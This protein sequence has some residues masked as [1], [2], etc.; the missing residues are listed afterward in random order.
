MRHFSILERAW[1][2]TWR[3]RALWIFGLLVALTAGGTSSGGGSGGNAAGQA[4]DQGVYGGLELP[5]PVIGFFVAL[6]VVLVIALILAALIFALFASIARYLGDSA[7]MQL[8]DREEADGT[9]PTLAAG[10]RLSWSTATLRLFALDV[11]VGIPTAIIS[12]VLILFS[13]TPLLLWFTEDVG[14]GIVGTVLAVGLFIFVLLFISLVSALISIFTPFYRRRTV[15]AERGV[16]AAL[17]EGVS[18]VFRHL[19]D[20]LLMWLIMIV[21]NILGGLALA[22]AALLLVLLVLLIV[23][24]PVLLF[25]WL[26]SAVLNTSLGYVI[27]V[28][29]MLPWFFGLVIMPSLL[30]KAVFEVFKSTV[31]TLTYREL[32]GL[33]SA[34]VTGEDDE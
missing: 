26:F 1:K 15:L 11:V 24:V 3:Y 7:L 17:G 19:G 8:I 27:G 29:G 18:L 5:D 13:A 23:G 33:E 4:M 6:I 25:G 2:K 20:V 16:F 10:F 12:F 32:L 14:A 22:M 21:V 9:T 30:L 34:A 28:I 31:W